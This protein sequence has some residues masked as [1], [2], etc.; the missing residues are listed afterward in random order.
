MDQPGLHVLF[1]ASHGALIAL[2]MRKI[3]SESMSFAAG[4]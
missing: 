4:S 2:N 3:M 1:H